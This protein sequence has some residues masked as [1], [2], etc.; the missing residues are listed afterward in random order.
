V[1]SLMM[2]E[3]SDMTLIHS[4]QLLLSSWIMQASL[5]WSMKLST[6]RIALRD[7]TS[8]LVQKKLQKRMIQRNLMITHISTHSFW[9][10]KSIYWF[11][12]ENLIC[13]MDLQH[14][15]DGWKI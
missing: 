12:P 11:M 4:K 6:S 5:N 14:N 13:R 7:H 15:S 1:F 10:A 3:S 9:K 8:H 2:V